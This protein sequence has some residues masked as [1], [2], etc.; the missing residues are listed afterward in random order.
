MQAH[1]DYLF[2]WMI[3][4]GTWFMQ[5][6]LTGFP[7][8]HSTPHSFVKWKLVKIM[9][10][11]PKKVWYGLLNYQRQINFHLTWFLW[12]LY[13][14]LWKHGYVVCH[15][16]K[17]W[18]LGNRE[19]GLRK[20]L[21]WVIDDLP[22]SYFWHCVPFHP[23][24]RCYKNNSEWLPR[25]VLWTPPLDCTLEEGESPQQNVDSPSAVSKCPSQALQPWGHK[26]WESF[27]LTHS[28]CNSQKKTSS[29]FFF[30]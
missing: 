17:Y 6:P 13:L 27:F 14:A 25:V 12:I 9:I 4:Q 24:T 5:I 16:Q 23:R 30:F 26:Q 10:L 29:F 22:A 3:V 15:Y 18:I 19:T 20:Q 8:P 21:H 28:Q 2:K 11:R 1:E 7:P